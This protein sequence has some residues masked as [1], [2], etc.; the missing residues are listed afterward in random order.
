MIE[1]I[2]DIN[3]DTRV[4]CLL[5]DPVSHSL[6]PRLHNSLICH[7]GLNLVY[8]A[9]RV[10]DIKSALSGLKAFNFMGANVTIPFKEAVIPYVDGIDE[11]ARTAGAINVI[12][13]KEGTLHGYNT[14]VYG[15]RKALPVRDKSIAIL[16][17]GGA[18]RA[19]CVALACNDL[20]VVARNEEKT[21]R[22]AREF[23]CRATTDIEIIKECDIIVNAT[24]VGMIPHVGESPVPRELLRETDT[25]FDMVYTPLHTQL[26]VDASSV[27]ARC[28][29]GMEMFIHQAVKSFEIWT[30]I[31]PDAEH[32]REVLS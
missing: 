28:I 11:P 31:L 12:A 9:C 1:R 15:I 23:Q 2:K 20:T 5:G 4:L 26:L 22:F 18:A 24:P 17:A 27:G 14:D 21:L 10:T 6:S 7:Y 32:A 29:S 13:E 3:A 25:V 19:A 30:G 8:V 16:G